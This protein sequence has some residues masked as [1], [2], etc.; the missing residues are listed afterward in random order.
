[1]E[2]INIISNGGA[3]DLIL[4]LRLSHLLNT[5]YPNKYLINNFLAARDET[6]NMIKVSYKDTN[7][8]HNIKQLPEDFLQSIKNQ[9]DIDSFDKSAQNY[10]VYPDT[11]FRGIGKFPCS[12]FGLSPLIIKQSRPLLGK[13]NP[14]NYISIHLNSITHGYTY[15]S[16][17][18]LVNSIAARFPDKKIYV[19]ILSSWNNKSLNLNINKQYP[20]IEVD[21]DADFSKVFGIL[22]KSEYSV[23]T[24]NGILHLLH[25]IGAP[26]L[27]LDPQFNRPAFEA[28]WRANGYFNSLD[29]KSLSDDIVNVIET[30]IKTP[31]TQMINTSNIFRKELFWDE[32]LVF[33]S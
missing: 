4:S 26:Y 29:I 15:H 5:I 33:K 30:Q 10:I 28:R 21:I 12:K 6:F 3:G 20:N 11:L 18:E 2:K 8:I 23:T 17:S 14:E 22:C 27:L 24:D 13:W 7:L 16:I 19:P 31:E 25:D 9:S 32:T 1:M